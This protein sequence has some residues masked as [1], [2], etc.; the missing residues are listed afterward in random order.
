M[1]LER[2]V[3]MVTLP[4][5]ETEDFFFLVEQFAILSQNWDSIS[6]KEEEGVS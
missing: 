6:K 4:V 3:H 2:T 5:S 1:L